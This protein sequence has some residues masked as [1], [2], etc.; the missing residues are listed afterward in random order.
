MA[1][2]TNYNSAAIKGPYNT[3]SAPLGMN[4]L[5]DVLNTVSPTKIRYTTANGNTYPV[6]KDK[7]GYFIIDKNGKKSYFTSNAAK[8][9]ISN[10][11][12][13][14][15]ADRF[16]YVPTTISKKD[17]EYTDVGGYS[18][19]KIVD[20]LKNKAL[21]AVNNTVGNNIGGQI[22]NGIGGLE[23]Y[24]Q[25][26][27]S[28]YQQALNELSNP[29]IWTVDELAKYYGVDNQYD[30]NY[31]LNMYNN[32]TDKYYTDAIAAQQKINKDSELSNSAYANSLLN[33]YLDSYNNAAPTAVGKGTIA[34]N[35][36]STLLG[37]DKANEEAS[38]GLN[39][40]VNS[41]KEK[42]NAEKASN[43]AL[44][45][46]RYTDIGNYLLSGN[47]ALNT[48]EVQNYINDLKALDTK[49]SGARNAQSTLAASAANAYNNNAQ[50]ALVTNQAAAQGAAENYRK[51][52]YKALYGNDWQT[53]YN[54]TN[55][56]RS[57]TRTAENGTV[58]S[59]SK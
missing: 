42:W 56:D 18:T 39:D 3:Q 23:A 48:A 10:L 26:E 38:S 53:Y 52:Q 58:N 16:N 31:L 4:P 35:A 49:Y 41:Y 1:N 25:N 50:A 55:Y 32:A 11:D 7:G 34:A 6:R 33:K 19:S 12:T 22:D 40:I 57:Q 37:A 28:K 14:L 21:D 27:I 54:N 47:T 13:T 51:N 8:T 43:D 44:A 30:M 15:N 17:Y 59:A 45:R 20:N 29:K 9:Y 24:Y 46:E 2:N 5:Q 36:L